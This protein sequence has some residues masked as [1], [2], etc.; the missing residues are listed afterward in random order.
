MSDLMESY[1][2]QQYDDGEYYLADGREGLPPVF[3]RR[4]SSGSP[5]EEIYDHELHRVLAEYEDKKQH[6]RLFAMHTRTQPIAKPAQP[7]QTHKERPVPGYV[8]QYVLQHYAEA[9]TL[10]NRIGHGVTAAEVLA[11]SGNESKWGNLDPELIKRNQQDPKKYPLSLARYGNFFGLH[12]DGPTGTYYTQENH[13][14]TPK[15]S[16][17]NGFMLSGQVFVDINLQEKLATGNI[18]ADPKAYF[19]ALNSR[20]PVSH[21]IYYAAANPHYAEDMTRDDSGRGPYILVLDAIE[22]LKKEGRL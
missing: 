22:Q 2:K 11:V 13:T 21:K 6:E 12:G 14:P 16:L 18:G 15:F 3:L 5:P 8:L 17:D 20:S 9:Q 10:A 7:V 1:W 19:K 4:S